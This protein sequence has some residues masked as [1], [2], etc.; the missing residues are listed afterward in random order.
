MR[1]SAGAGHTCAVLENGDVL[2]WGQSAWGV[3]GYGNTENVG[4]DEVPASVGPVE[5]GGPA[6]QVSAGTYHTCALLE[7]GEVLCWGLGLNGELGYGNTDTIGDDEVPASIGP[8]DVGAPVV[9]V[10]TGERNTCVRLEGNDVK[11]WGAIACGLGYIVGD[12]ETPASAETVPLGGKAVHLSAGSY[13]VCA[14][15][16]DGGV[17]CWGVDSAGDL[18]YGPDVEY[19]GDNETPADMGDVP[20]F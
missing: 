11:C 14:L 17:R 5:L 1:V 6:V 7:T 2:C 15:T 20:L 16:E 8:V 12:D 19:V 10:V 18:G 4:D 3:L 9:D 13:H